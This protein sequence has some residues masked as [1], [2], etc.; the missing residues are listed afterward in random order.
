M[1]FWSGKAWKIFV[2]SGETEF[3][4]VNLNIIH[5]YMTITYIHW[6]TDPAWLSLTNER[7]FYD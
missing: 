5:I 7:K 3:I 6:Y 4:F 2:V 1:H